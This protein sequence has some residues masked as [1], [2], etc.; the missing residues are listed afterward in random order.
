M[1][2]VVLV[3]GRGGPDV[4]HVVQ[5]EVPT[6]RS[7][8]VRIRVEAAG[9]AFGDVMR[10]RGVLAPPGA[11]TPGYDV[12]GVIDA[13]GE[14]VSGDWLGRRVAAMM[15]SVGL[16][17]YAD[18]VCVPADRLARVPDGVPPAEAVAL[19]L[20]YITA[21]QLLHRFSPVRAGQRILI[22]GAAGGVG[23]AL[24]ELGEKLGLEMY[25]TASS[26]KHDLVRERGGV[27]IDYRS[28]D[29]VSR[30][31][32]LTHGGGVDVVFDSI[33][34]AHLRRSYQTL[35]PRGTLV[36][37]GVSGDL[38]RGWLGVIA[39]FWPFL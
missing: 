16:G 27:P 35:R 4:L 11:F 31:A 22:H 38:S 9:V 37:F 2:R 23:T 29:F 33:G 12:V 25:G 14:T 20:N 18:H 32:E 15:P 7:K 28:E 13:V 1:S 5:R 30:V 24:L 17:G 10:R 36:S 34:G 6:P 26:A 8:A 3:R 19:G 21:Y 39:G